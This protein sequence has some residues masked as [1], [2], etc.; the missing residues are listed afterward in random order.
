M[1]TLMTLIGNLAGA[2]WRRRVLLG[3]IVIGI[4]G[5]AAIACFVV[6]PTYRASTLL[7]PNTS[8][9]GW[10]AAFGE[11]SGLAGQ[12]GFDVGAGDDPARPTPH[13]RTCESTTGPTSRLLP[14]CE[15]YTFLSRSG[16][17]AQRRTQA[18]RDPGP[19]SVMERRARRARPRAPRPRIPAPSTTAPARISI[20][21]SKACSNGLPRP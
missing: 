6:R 5:L 19:G 10:N 21:W 12:F 14:E 20:P 9:S 16:L 17:G 13:P 2:A 1:E 18:R 15:S 8:G 7:V 3:I 11:L 4:T